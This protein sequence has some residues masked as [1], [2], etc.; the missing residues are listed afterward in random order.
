MG[1]TFFLFKYFKA[2][3]IN[4]EEEQKQAKEQIIAHENLI[5]VI[6]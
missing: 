3:E 1:F 5:K 6:N 2:I 4:V